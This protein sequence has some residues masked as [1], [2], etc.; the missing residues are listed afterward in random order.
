MVE[1]ENVFIVRKMSC[2]NFPK[3]YFVI[4]EWVGAYWF[5]WTD[6]GIFTSY[7]AALIYAEKELSNVRH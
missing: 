1:T 3:E 5:E 6:A 7:N 2:D 4:R